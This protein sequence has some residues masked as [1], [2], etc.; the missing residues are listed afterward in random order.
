MTKV[1]QLMIYNSSIQKSKNV[2]NN[3]TVWKK[4]AQD[5]LK[6]VSTKMFKD[7]IFNVYV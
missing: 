1:I 4:C 2:W 5:R 6:I 3:S 7:H